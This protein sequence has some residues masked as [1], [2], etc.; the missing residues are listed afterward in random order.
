MDILLYQAS[1]P[2]TGMK[3]CFTEAV[4]LVQDLYSPV[5]YI[6]R[7]SAEECFIPY[8]PCVSGMNVR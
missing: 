1:S 4:L 8:A 6:S 5:F 3:M 7:L 2:V